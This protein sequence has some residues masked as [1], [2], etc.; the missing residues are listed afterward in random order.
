MTITIDKNGVIKWNFYR[1]SYRKS[2][3]RK[4]GQRLLNNIIKYYPDYSGLILVI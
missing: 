2:R 3:W 1:K 4:I